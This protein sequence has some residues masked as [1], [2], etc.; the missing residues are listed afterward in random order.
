MEG[1]RIAKRI[2]IECTVEGDMSDVSM[3]IGGSKYHIRDLSLYP[4]SHKNDYLLQKH[5]KKF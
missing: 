4:N 3:L 5:T 2:R 1:V